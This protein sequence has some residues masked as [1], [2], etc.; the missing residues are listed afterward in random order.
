MFI[1]AALY[2]FNTL[3]TSGFAKSYSGLAVNAF[4]KWLTFQSITEQGCI[5]LVPP[6]AIMAEQEQLVAHK[7]AVT[8]RGKKS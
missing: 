2:S 7:N 5:N 3:P 1:P 6:V 8:I 4:G